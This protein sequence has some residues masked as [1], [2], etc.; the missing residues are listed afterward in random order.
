MILY[1]NQ[2]CIILKLFILAIALYPQYLFALSVVFGRWGNHSLWYSCWGL[3]DLISKL[4]VL[5]LNVLFPLSSFGTILLRSLLVG[6]W[7]SSSLLSFELIILFL[8]IST[9]F[10]SNS[11]SSSFTDRIFDD[12]S[13]ISVCSIGFS[14]SIIINVKIVK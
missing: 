2:W 5:F 6:V 7:T 12:Q 3:S 9:R 1:R 13:S 4:L 11:L 14:T 10:Q 8:L